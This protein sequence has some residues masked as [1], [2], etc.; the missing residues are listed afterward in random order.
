MSSLNKIQQNKNKK[1]KSFF[2]LCLLFFIVSLFFSYY[3]GLMINVVEAGPIEDRLGGL[4]STKTELESTKTKP[5]DAGGFDNVNPHIFV[6]DAALK[7]TEDKGIMN[8]VKAFLSKKRWDELIAKLL[9][10]GSS[11]LG[12]AIRGAL[13]TIAYD[14]AT[15]L[16]SGKEGQKPLFITENWEE[17]YLNIADEAA[18]NFIE[19]LGKEGIFGKKFNLCEPDFNVKL[20]I[21]LGLRN[22]ARPEMNKP[23]CTFMKMTENWEKAIT[24]NDF[25]TKFQ[26]MFNPQSNDLGIALSLQTKIV[27][28][29]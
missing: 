10:A 11:A 6:K 27:D 29:I 9:T 2:N 14:T 17:Y 19:S 25:L 24:G 7:K 4:E 5:A 3:I 13:N 22:Q 15:W 18:G 20:R 23:A 26:D 16:G 1:N 21:G 12:I 8:S 28:D